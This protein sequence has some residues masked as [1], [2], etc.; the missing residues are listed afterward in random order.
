MFISYAERSKRVFFDMEAETIIKITVGEDTLEMTEAEARAVRD[1]LN[2]IFGPDERV[3]REFF[4]Y[5]AQPVSPPPTE[6]P[7]GGMPT[8]TCGNLKG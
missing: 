2:S 4:P 1:K 7:W 8:I 5:P 3:V 6:F